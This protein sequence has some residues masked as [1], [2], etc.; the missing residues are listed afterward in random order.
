MSLRTLFLI[1]A[2]AL[3]SL[4]PWAARAS[5]HPLM[6]S[7]RASSVAEGPGV[8][9]GEIARISGGGAQERTRL[10]SLRIAALPPNGETLRLSQRLVRATLRRARAGDVLLTGARVARVRQPMRILG[11]REVD[12]AV[13]RYLAG[14][15]DL[16]RGDMEVRAVRMPPQKIALPRGKLTLS[17]EAP[18]HTRFIGPTPL[19]VIARNGKREVRRFWVSADVAAYTQVPVPRQPIRV[20]ERLSASQFEMRRK[21]LARL[22][23]DVVTRMADLEGGKPLRPLAPGEAVRKSDIKLPFM[24]SQGHLVRIIARNRGL[25]IFALGKALDR[26]RRGQIVRVLNVDSRRVVHG[27]VVD[28]SVVE[29]LF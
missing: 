23:S 15:L 9:L 20:N 18:P 3:P 13:R 17:V 11:A 5:N 6:V 2:L 29:V 7:L 24:I 8:R 4:S 12:A 19:M 10:A 22:P 26:G 1:A 28:R 25:T 14:R 27:R 21:N 16:G